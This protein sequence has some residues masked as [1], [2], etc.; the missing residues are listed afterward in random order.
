M[1][2]DSV[3]CN[4]FTTFIKILTPSVFYDEYM[5]ERYTKHA[6]DVLGHGEKKNKK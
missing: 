1:H 5:P 2:T 6:V 4:P 3:V